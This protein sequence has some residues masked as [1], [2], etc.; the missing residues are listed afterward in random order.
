MKLTEKTKK[1]LVITG[2]MILGIGLLAAIGMQFGQPPS[3][4]VLPETT[5]TVTE[6][7]V[8]PGTG[9]ET[10]KAPKESV[11][12]SGGKTDLVIQP[13]TEETNETTGQAGTD[14][15]DTAEYPA[16][17]DKT[18][19]AQG[20]NADGSNEE[21]GWYKAGRTARASGS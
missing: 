2:S 10:Q 20:R 4:D 13:G 8:D 6:V 11:E 9:L 18:R 19:A 21:A 14:G 15:P 16:G 1:Y 12:E 7:I 17:T 3:E 5:Q